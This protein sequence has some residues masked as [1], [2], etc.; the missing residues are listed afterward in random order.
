MKKILLL[1]IY[2]NAIVSFSQSKSGKAIYGVESNLN[3]K[4]ISSITFKDSTNRGQDVRHKMITKILKDSE[5]IKDTE[6][7]LLFSNN[8]AIYKPLNN[9]DYNSLSIIKITAIL[10]GDFFFDFNSKVTLNKIE[11]KGEKFLVEDRLSRFNWKTTN[12]TKYIGNYKCFK[13]IGE[14]EFYSSIADKHLIIP[15]EAWFTL[16]IKIPAGPEGTGGLPGLIVELKLKSRTYYLKRIMFSDR[17]NI[18]VPNKE[19]VISRNKF[20]TS[21]RLLYLK[22]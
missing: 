22:H 4:Q 21:K 9:L 18:Q 7:E 11:Y 17:E 10:S 6:F 1:V 16:D 2:L 12:E 13:A 14:R 20:N 19:N 8:F 3:Y 5:D 15:L